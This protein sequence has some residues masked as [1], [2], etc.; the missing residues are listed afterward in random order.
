MTTESTESQNNMSASIYFNL[1]KGIV[2]RAREGGFPRFRRRV[3]TR[4]TR[5]AIFQTTLQTIANV[6]SN[7]KHIT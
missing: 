3:S 5:A 1:R 6:A 4:S 7:E 2:L